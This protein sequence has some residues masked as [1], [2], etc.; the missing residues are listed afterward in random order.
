WLPHAYLGS[1]S[2]SFDPQLQ[3]PFGLVIPEHAI[4]P[5]DRLFALLL[6]GFGQGL[7]AYNAQIFLSFV[8]AGC[9]M[10]LL[11][12]YVT[13]S[14]LAALVAGFAFTFSPFHL[15]VSMQYNALASIQWIP[16]FLLALLVLLR[17][18][19]KRDAALT[20]AAFALVLLTSYYYAWF[21]AWFTLLVLAYVAAAAALRARRDRRPRE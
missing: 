11:A 9:T 4:Q 8:L 18:G 21:L 15:A 12:R 19:R 3:A 16:L 1:G 6:G 7:G 20:G 5:M 10:Y 2:A 13:E 14:R 17:R